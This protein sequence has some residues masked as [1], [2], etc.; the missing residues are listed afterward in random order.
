MHSLSFKKLEEYIICDL[1]FCKFLNR[2]YKLLLNINIIQSPYTKE[3]I[4]H[5]LLKNIV[6]KMV[7][8][9]GVVKDQRLEQTNLNAER[10]TEKINKY[11]AKFRDEFYNF[12]DNNAEL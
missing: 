11:L 6:M 8:L 9:E 3:K 4:Q 10:L 7:K 5:I 12:H 2:I 1:Y